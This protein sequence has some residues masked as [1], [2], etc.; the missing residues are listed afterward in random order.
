[1]SSD[2][3]K[4]LKAIREAEGFSQASFAELTGINIGVI[5]N[6]E[7]GKQNP[8]ISVIDR[9]LESKDFEK[10]TLW[11]MTDK[12]NEAYGQIAPTLSP[13]GQGNTLNRRSAK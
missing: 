6:Y 12:T 3:G 2:R 4:K 8:G 5:K 11:L 7:Y 1:M 13:D 10:Y 9:V